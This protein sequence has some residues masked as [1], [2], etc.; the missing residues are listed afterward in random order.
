MESEERELDLRE[1]EAK[2]A[3][4]TAALE[5]TTE[6]PARKSG[7]LRPGRVVFSELVGV[8]SSGLLGSS[9]DSEPL[10]V[11]GLFGFGLSSDGGPAVTTVSFRPRAD[12]FLTDHLTVGLAL[13]AAYASVS[14]VDV[15]SSASADVVSSASPVSTTRGPSRHTLGAAPRV[16]WAVDL[17]RVVL[18]PNIGGAYAVTR[19][20]EESTALGTTPSTTRKTLSFIVDLDVV[21]PLTSHLLLDVVPTLAYRRTGYSAFDADIVDIGL[22]A[23]L[24]L[25]F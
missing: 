17:G 24:G 19:T 11:G 6:A 3:A 14:N 16:G 22:R 5:P 25:T 13:E 4:R 10:F 20:S 1:R 21:F 9:V 8:S 18:W 15:V 23:H 7:F 2:V 12:L